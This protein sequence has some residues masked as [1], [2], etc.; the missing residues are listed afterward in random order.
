VYLTTKF[1]FQGVQFRLLSLNLEVGSGF[2][3]NSIISYKEY[4]IILLSICQA[5]IVL[6]TYIY[7]IM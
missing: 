3:V 2:L 5:F 7:T 1:P 6:D 4:C